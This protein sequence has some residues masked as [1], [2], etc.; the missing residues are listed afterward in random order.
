MEPRRPFARVT[1]RELDG[2][3]A[4]ER[5]GLTPALREPDDPP[6]QDVDRRDHFE[7]AC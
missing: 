5:D 7:L 3:A 2:I 1:L 6:C 4:L